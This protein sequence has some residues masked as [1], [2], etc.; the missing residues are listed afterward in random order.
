M[1]DTQQALTSQEA[2]VQTIREHSGLFAACLDY[3]NSAHVAS[4]QL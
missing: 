1:S 2:I 3:R 4:N